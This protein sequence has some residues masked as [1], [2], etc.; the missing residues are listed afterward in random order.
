[1]NSA[2]NWRVRE[3]AL[4]RTFRFQ[5]FVDTFGFMARVALLAE[6]ANHHPDWSG[7]YN[8]ITIRLTTHDAG[9]VTERDH[10]LARE[11]DRLV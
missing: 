11:I 3:N 8:H 1:M 6:R 7:G 10:Q 2:T 9:G 5:N 4:E